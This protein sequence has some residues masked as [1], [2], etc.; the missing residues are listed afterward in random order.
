MQ[1]PPNSYQC[2]VK[3][4]GQSL[5]CAD[6]RRRGI[7]IIMSRVADAKQRPNPYKPTI[8]KC[9]P[10]QLATLCREFKELRQQIERIGI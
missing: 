10:R 3:R 1:R 8:Q 2:S 5:R 4:F 7:F 6:F 9:N